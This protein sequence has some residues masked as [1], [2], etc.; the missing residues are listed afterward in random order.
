M[1]QEKA[2][3]FAMTTGVTEA[4]F[5]ANNGPGWLEKFKQ[6]N[7][8]TTVKSEKSISRKQSLASIKQANGARTPTSSSAEA[9]GSVAA[10]AMMHTVSSDSHNTQGGSPD[11]YL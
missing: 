2:W 6:K 9:D 11:S 4:Q 10:P 7:N 3:H 5:K 8:I 1:I